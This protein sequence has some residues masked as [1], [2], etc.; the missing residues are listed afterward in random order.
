MILQLFN[1][2]NVSDHLTVIKVMLH[3]FYL[4]IILMAFAS[5]KDYISLLGKHCGCLDGLTTIHDGDNLFHLFLVKPSQHVIDY[6]LR[7]LGTRIIARNDDTI[8]LTNSLLGHQRTLAFVSV[9]ASTTDSDDL[10]FSIQHFMDGIE[11][12]L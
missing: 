4:L 3:T 2:K 10:A 7:L 9:T 11:Y 6:V 12:I 8:A 1:P 5:N